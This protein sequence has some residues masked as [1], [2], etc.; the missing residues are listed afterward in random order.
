MEPAQSII[1]K[2]GGPSV[3][4]G[5]VGI[6]RTRV[7]SW[8]RSRAAGGTDGRIPQNHIEPLMTLAREKGVD[9]KIEDFFGFDTTAIEPERAA[10]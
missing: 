5:V 1:R 3:V 4:A 9:L 6:H 10:S 2:L 7:S 8:Q